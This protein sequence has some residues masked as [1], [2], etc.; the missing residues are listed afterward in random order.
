MG[1][2]KNLSKELLQEFI[3]QV[4]SGTIVLNID[5]IFQLDDVAKAHQYMENNKAKGKN[6][7][8]TINWILQYHLK[9]RNSFRTV[10]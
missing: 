1:E 6:S 4:E 5:K 7:S 9:M 10:I 8:D 2:S 3:D